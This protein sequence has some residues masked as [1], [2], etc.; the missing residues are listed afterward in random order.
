MAFLAR[1]FVC[2]LQD[3]RTGASMSGRACPIVDL[4]FWLV[5]PACAIASCASWPGIYTWKNRQLGSTIS[6]CTGTF[7]W[8]W[9]ARR[10]VVSGPK[11]KRP[12]EA[13]LRQQ[14]RERADAS[15]ATW[16]SQQE[17]AE[18]ERLASAR[19]HAASDAAAFLPRA[20][21]SQ[22]A[23]EPFTNWTPALADLAD[24]LREAGIS[25]HARAD[26]R[27]YLGSMPAGKLPRLDE[28][29]GIGSS[30]WRDA[31]DKI[32]WVYARDVLD[33][34]LRRYCHLDV[35]LVV[36]PAPGRNGFA[37][38]TAGR[39]LA[40][41]R[42]THAVGPGREM[43]LGNFLT[44]GE[45]WDQVGQALN[46]A[47]AGT[48]PQSVAS[49]AATVISSRRFDILPGSISPELREACIEASRRIRLERRTAFGR[50]IIL[51]GGGCEL[52]VEPVSRRK[53]R[54]QVPFAFSNDSHGEDAQVQ[55]ELALIGT[56]PLPVLIT[57]DVSDSAAYAAWA[58]MLL[59]F[60]ELTC[61]SPEPAVR[62]RRAELPP[63]PPWDH[64]R[65]GHR[66]TAG[67]SMRPLRPW[68]AS[69]DPAGPWY[70][71]GGTYV[72]AHVS[73]LPFGR[74]H[75]PEAAQFALQAGISLEQ[76]ETWVRD[77]IR[78]VPQDAEIRFRWRT[79]AELATSN[80]SP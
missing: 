59:G 2:A 58:Y 12:S 76:Q 33:K 39:E 40:V 17:K 45:H 10:C 49:D 73:R 36:A 47:G 79:P 74:E 11:K 51:E 41:I 20:A 61:N 21:N 34:A 46:G 72:A 4:R 54:L 15:Y 18:R 35:D 66:R 30:A 8:E 43:I 1:G 75:S 44:G 71:A 68:N 70:T 52:M 7:G 57:S 63:S 22:V 14:R 29:T 38:V 60:A 32:V 6:A 26:R 25:V 37:L 5:Q 3:G 78:G 31:V 53:G 65:S 27:L 64:I 19:E 42:A 55:G 9:A 62:E 69:L 23:A 28:S 80:G 77:Y 48:S 50:R 24:F 13:E 16:R 56:D 67:E